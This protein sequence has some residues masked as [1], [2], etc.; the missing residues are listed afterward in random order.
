MLCSKET[1]QPWMA[2]V[3]TFSDFER[4]GISKRLKLW[5]LIILHH[6]ATNLGLCFL[7]TKNLKKKKG[8]L[9]DWLMLN[10]YFYIFD[11]EGLDKMH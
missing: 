7:Y 10:E 6:S 2:R 3:K 11:S 5:V 1:M 9:L 4:R 8:S